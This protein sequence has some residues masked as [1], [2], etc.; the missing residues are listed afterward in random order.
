MVR[1]LTLLQHKLDRSKARQLD[2][3]RLR[4]LRASVSNTQYTADCIYE[5]R[6]VRLLGTDEECAKLFEIE[7]PQ[8]L[9][10]P[11]LEMFYWKRV[12]FDEFHELEGFGPR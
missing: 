12:V 3:R 2:R 11:L 9:L 5:Y 7:E 6:R 1:L 4:E 10:F 8:D